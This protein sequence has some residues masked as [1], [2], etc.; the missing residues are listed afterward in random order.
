MLFEKFSKVEQFS[1]FVSVNRADA[2]K[3][4]ETMN[5]DPMFGSQFASCDRSV[6]RLLVALVPGMSHQELEQA[7]RHQV[8]VRYIHDLCPKFLPKAARLRA[9]DK[10]DDDK[11]KKLFEKFGPIDSAMVILHTGAKKKANPRDSALSASKA[12]RMLRRR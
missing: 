10:L 11:L 8:H 1:Q 4:L 6:I 12:M 3:A 7:H 2:E 9:Y 5:F